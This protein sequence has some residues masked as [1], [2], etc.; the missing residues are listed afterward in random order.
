MF[1]V[2]HLLNFIYPNLFAPTLQLILLG[3]HRLEE[4]AFTA[5][6]SGHRFLNFKDFLVATR[7]L[8]C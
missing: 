4:A 1:D 8:N 5:A 7:R 6:C 3:R 2:S